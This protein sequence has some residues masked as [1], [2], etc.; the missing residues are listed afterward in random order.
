MINFKKDPEKEVNINTNNNGREIAGFSAREGKNV[1][2]RSTREQM[3]YLIIFVLFV[4]V[5]IFVDLK[6]T[7]APNETSI[8]TQQLW[9]FE[10]GEA[11][12]LDNIPSGNQ[13]FMLDV[14][15][16]DIHGQALC[17]KSVDTTFRIF[18]DGMEIYNYHPRT[19]NRFGLS[20]GMYVHTI[21]LPDDTKMLTMKTEPIFRERPADLNDVTIDNAGHYMTN[22]FQRK[23][24]FIRSVCRYHGGGDT[25][26]SFWAWRRYTDA[27]C[28]HRLYR[29][30][31]SVCTDRLRW[32]Q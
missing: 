22:F 27:L 14:S 7:A 20:Y 1:N 12:D 32:L 26:P 2:V 29:L 10:T 17:M 13:K 15:K 4:A 3:A 18:A 5:S 16:Y 23:L 31:S 6:G 21:A 19:P 8:D 24:V 25:V 30:R 9:T 28:R 11:A